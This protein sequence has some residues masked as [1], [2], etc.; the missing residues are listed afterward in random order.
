MLIPDKVNFKPK[1]IRRGIEGHFILIKRT[2]NQEE[3]TI[4]NI[5]VPANP[6]SLNTHYFSWCWWLT[7][8]QEAEILLDT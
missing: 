1:L 6:T 3:I 2:I 4:V 5:H 8:T 7:A